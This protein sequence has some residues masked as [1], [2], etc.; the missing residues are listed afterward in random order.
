MLVL[1]STPNTAIGAGRRTMMKTKDRRR[2]GPCV[3][4]QCGKFQ[5]LYSEHP[6]DSYHYSE[7]FYKL[8][9]RLVGEER[10]RVLCPVCARGS[11]M[12]QFCAW[13]LY[14]Y[15]HPKGL[16]EWKKQA[17]SEQSY[18]IKFRLRGEPTTD[19][20]LIDPKGKI[21]LWCGSSEQRAN[22]ATRAYE[23]AKSCRDTIQ[24]LAFQGLARN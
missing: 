11:E 8:G 13:F 5:M 4:S 21:H 22:E 15:F 18:E 19:L 17:V 1:W 20:V 2:Y 16:L 6:E 23:F 14:R 3:C 12:Q 10:R 9:W 24:K 7:R